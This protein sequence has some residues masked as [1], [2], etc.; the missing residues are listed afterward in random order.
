MT[1]LILLILTA[2]GTAAALAWHRRK[3]TSADA[4]FSVQAPPPVDPTGYRREIQLHLRQLPALE[5]STLRHLRRQGMQ[6]FMADRDSRVLRALAR[7]NL[8]HPMGSSAF[9]ADAY[10]YRVPDIV[11]E[12]LAGDPRG[13]SSPNSFKR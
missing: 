8:L 6:T 1:L 9:P 2:A 13:Q 7:R 10:P 11:W 5:I 12:E 4:K 3:K